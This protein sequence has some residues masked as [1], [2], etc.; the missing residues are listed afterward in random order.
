MVMSKAMTKTRSADGGF[1]KK[2]IVILGISRARFTR[3]LSGS[4]SFV[5]LKKQAVESLFYF[6]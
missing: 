6:A 1:K 5:S 2:K 3:Q 4:C